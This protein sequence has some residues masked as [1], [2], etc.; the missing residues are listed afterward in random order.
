MG[1]VIGFNDRLRYISKHGRLLRWIVE[2]EQSG[3][4]LTYNQTLEHCRT[5]EPN[6][7]PENIL[8]QLIDADAII[9]VAIMLSG[10]AFLKYLIIYIPP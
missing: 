6:V 2:R 8:S 1:R 10:I 4:S 7:L 3:K 9:P 5:V